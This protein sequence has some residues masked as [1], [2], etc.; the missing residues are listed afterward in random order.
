M[1]ENHI[2]MDGEESYEEDDE[3]SEQEETLL[4]F[5][6]LYRREEKD[7]LR[8]IANFSK[9]VKAWIAKS[10]EDLSAQSMLKAHLPTALLLSINAPFRD[11]REKFSELLR[12][13][14]VI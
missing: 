13:V 8:F 10:A 5:G 2:E 14:K 6:G 11:I 4:Y 3:I 7:R 1:A 12:E 9:C